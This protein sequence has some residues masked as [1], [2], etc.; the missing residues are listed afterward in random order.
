MSAPPPEL[1]S[2]RCPCRCKSTLVFRK[3]SAGSVVRCPNTAHRFKLHRWQPFGRKQWDECRE[4]PVLRSV[5]ELLKVS[6]SVRKRRLLAVAVSRT[7]LDWCRNAHFLQALEAADELAETG[8]TTVDLAALDLHLQPSF[9]FP[10]FPGSGP[11]FEH[12]Q[13]AALACIAPTPGLEFGPLEATYGAGVWLAF[14]DI[15]PNPF[16]P[17]AVSAELRTAA[18]VGLGE[19][20]YADRA[21]GHLPILADAL[22]AAGCTDGP[23]LD[24]LRGPGPHHRG[25]WALD[26]VL[27][28]A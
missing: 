3:I 11:T 20:A 14:K 4:L 24:H 12:W 19:T 18:V 17:P 5:L 26:A 22:E 15:I 1:V 25:C 21:F 8:T 23:L 10:G 6:P 28:Q 7:C 27:G 16:R 9:W 2:V 13:T